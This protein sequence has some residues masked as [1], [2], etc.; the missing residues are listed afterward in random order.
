[1]RVV[2]RLKML[3]SGCSP[4]VSFR[5]RR[6]LEFCVERCLQPSPG[7]ILM[8]L[9]FFGHRN[10]SPIAHDEAHEHQT[11]LRKVRAEAIASSKVE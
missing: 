11:L 4:D 1:M 5:Q 8:Q 10:M 9:P 2:L 3:T 7:M 6:R